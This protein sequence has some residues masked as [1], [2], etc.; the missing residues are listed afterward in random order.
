LYKIRAKFLTYSE[1]AANSQNPPN[2]DNS[3][4]ASSSQSSEKS[5]ESFVVSTDSHTTD[6]DEQNE[7]LNST[8]ESFGEA[9]VQLEGAKKKVLE[10]ASR[11]MNDRM[12]ILYE[13]KDINLPENSFNINMARHWH[14]VKKDAKI[15]ILAA[16]LPE[17]FL[18]GV[19]EEDITKFIGY[20][21]K[22]SKKF[23]QEGHPHL[24]TRKHFIEALELKEAQIYD[25]E[26][27]EEPEGIH[28]RN[29]SDDDIFD[30]LKYL[31]YASD[32]SPEVD[33]YEAFPDRMRH[34]TSE[35]F[36]RCFLD[37]SIRNLYGIEEFNKD[38]KIKIR[39]GRRLCHTKFLLL[40]EE[41]NKVRV[42][43]EKTE[44]S[45]HHFKKLIPKIF[46]EPRCKDQF[47]CVCP[48][49]FNTRNI[50]GKGNEKI[51]RGFS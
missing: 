19:A 1:L 24:M 3:S 46:V 20:F 2:P 4:S 8:R 32:D 23:A 39:C 50:V 5:S 38:G 18:F 11:E 48:P 33:V 49:C 41:M 9:I 25:L 13:Q 10:K 36:V 17:E 37:P 7:I 43:E 15:T 47:S 44:I 21:N 16:V 31:Y 14:H 27:I 29:I 34:K 26:N 30:V 22:I 51:L 6:E 28:L 35:N 45:I 40:F 42:R 12:I